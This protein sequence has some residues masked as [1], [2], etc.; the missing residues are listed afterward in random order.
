[1]NEQIN[2]DKVREQV[3]RDG[4]DAAKQAIDTAT[5]KL[6]DR[7]FDP[8]QVRTLVKEGAKKAASE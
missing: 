2:S 6:T 3:R 8:G 4:Y 7:G 1:M 5:K